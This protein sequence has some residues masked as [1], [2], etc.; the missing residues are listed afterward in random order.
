MKNIAVIVC[1]I[2]TAVS[3]LAAGVAIGTARGKPN[4]SDLDRQL[5]QTQIEAYRAGLKMFQTVGKAQFAE[6]SDDTRASSAMT[7]LKTIRSQLQ[8][9][10]AQ[11]DE[12]WPD[13]FAKQMLSYTDRQGRCKNTLSQQHPFGPYLLRVPVNPYTGESDLAIVRD[14]S[15]S[16]RPAEDMSKGWWYNAATG[17]FRCHL[18]DSM[19]T[20]DGKKINEM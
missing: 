9:Y 4:E 7:N 18:P 8:L 2:C 10:K 16:Y 1:L 15:A 12:L 11:H 3:L 17:E 5:K 6:A 19:L 13:D 14:A 20:H